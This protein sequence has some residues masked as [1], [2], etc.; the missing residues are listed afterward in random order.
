MVFNDVFYWS[1]GILSAIGVIVM[2][3]KLVRKLN[4]VADDI[5]GEPARA[6]GE[7]R[8]GWGSRLFNIEANQADLK[9][10]QRRFDEGQVHLIRRVSELDSKLAQVNHRVESVERQFEPDHGYSIRDRIDHI[11][12]IIKRG[13]RNG[14]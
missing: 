13:E 9:E 2:V 1:A 10:S 6:T 11:E 4:H 8:P 14:N 3:V 12:D 7:A 5:L